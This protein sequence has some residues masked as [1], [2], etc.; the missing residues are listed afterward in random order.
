MALHVNSRWSVAKNWLLPAN[1]GS[2]VLDDGPSR[3]RS[4][5][6]V[7]VLQAPPTCRVTCHVT[8]R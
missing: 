5:E 2:I 7:Q 1:I 6:A 8:Q 3:L 4:P